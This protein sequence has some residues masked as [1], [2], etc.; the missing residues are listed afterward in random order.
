MS[1]QTAAL[2]YAINHFDT[3]WAQLEKETE[4]D[5]KNYIAAV[6]TWETDR[7]K[8]TFDIDNDAVWEYEKR[9]RLM[10][11]S[12]THN[13]LPPIEEALMYLKNQ[14]EDLQ[15]IE[16]EIT[17][18]YKTIV[19]TYH[20]KGHT[21]NADTLIK[22]PWVPFYLKYTKD[23]PFIDKIITRLKHDHNIG[24]ITKTVTITNE[25]GDT[26]DFGKYDFE[27]AK[28]AYLI[29]HHRNLWI[30][31]QLTLIQ[32][33][34]N[35]AELKA[36]YPYN[37]DYDECADDSPYDI[38]CRQGLAIIDAIVKSLTDYPEASL[39]T[40]NVLTQMTDINKA[41]QNTKTKNANASEPLQDICNYLNTMIADMC[42]SEIDSQETI[43]RLAQDF[44]RHLAE[45]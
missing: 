13:N 25:K 7:F 5:K 28:D 18:G 45:K 33:L 43:D 29:N 37:I 26:I 38:Y 22:A 40:G 12:Y 21:F 15:R 1:L 6:L 30:E 24:P 23:T 27:F 44:I 41:C 16:Q 36:H 32:F 9:E 4:K 3:I 31:N 10:L 2:T 19:V 8:L 35:M 34:E 11:F 39:A 20:Y 14:L 17:E 42:I